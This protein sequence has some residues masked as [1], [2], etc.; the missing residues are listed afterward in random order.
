MR[1]SRRWLF[2][3]SGILAA[4]LLAALWL[5]GTESGTRWLVARAE[6]FLPEA[7]TLTGVS[8]T[9]LR[10][11]ELD[12]VK[13]LD[14]DI[15]VA[16]ESVSISVRPL[17]LISRNVIIDAFD[18]AA[19][20]VTLAGGGDDSDDPAGGLPEI[21]LPVDLRIFA[22]S[23]R[24]ID[25][26]S[27][28]FTREIDAVSFAGRLSG[29]ALEIRYF[30][31]ASSWLDIDI[32][33]DAQLSGRYPASLAA[34]WAWKTLDDAFSG[35]LS[36]DGDLRGFD[37]DHRLQAPVAVDS[38]GS[39][40][41]IDGVPR[42]DI[43][44]RWGAI[45]WPIPGGA[46][47]ARDGRLVTEGNLSEINV[48]LD[49]LAEWPGYPEQQLTLSGRADPESFAVESL[50]LRGPMGTAEISG[51]ASWSPTLAVALDYAVSSVD[52]SQLAPEIVS[53]LN[54]RGS[55]TAEQLGDRITA[56]ASITELDGTLNGLTVDGTANASSDGDQ[57]RIIDTQLRVGSN[58]VRLDGS[59]SET[60]LVRAA[61]DAPQLADILPELS[62]SVA[63]EI[64]V[65]GARDAPDV[66]FELSGN[67]LGWQ[68]T[69]N[70]QTLVA[71]GSLSRQAPSLVS[72]DAE[73][74]RFGDQALDAIGVEL[75]GTESRHSLTVSGA[76]YDSELAIELAGSLEGE[77]WTG[78]LDALSVVSPLIARW[79]TRES[80]DVSVSP[81]GFIVDETCLYQAETA[82][83]LC[84]FATADSSD[85][86]DARLQLEALSL[87][88]VQLP[89][90][91]E[92]DTSGQLHATIDGR[93]DGQALNA[94]TQLELRDGTVTVLYDEEPVVI[95]VS[96]L[97][98]EATVRANT[99]ASSLQLALG[100]AARATA[101]LGIDDLFDP[102][103]AITGRTSVAVP[104]VSTIAA[105]IPG[106]AEPE[107]AVDGT[108]SLSGR[109][110]APVFA[111]DVRLRDGRF[112]I[113]AAG[114]TVSDVSL[115]VTQLAP[116]QL[117]VLGSARS[118]EGQVAVTGRTLISSDTGLRSE[119]SIEGENVELARRPDFSVTASPTIDIVFD[120]RST[121]INGEL[122]IPSA[123]IRLRDIPA[124][125]ASPSPDTIVHE[126]DDTETP[127]ARVIDIDVSTS[128]GDDVNFSGFGL[129]TRLDG[130]L[131]LRGGNT[132]AY[133]GQGRVTLIG[134]EYKSYGQELEI[135]EGEL[136]FSGPLDNPRL[137]V[138]AVRRIDDI[139]AGI[140]L[141][142][143]PLQ[144]Q[145][146]LYSEPG[147]TDAEILS[148]L[149]T[150]R[151]L[152][153]ASDGDDGELLNQAAFSLGLSGAGAVVSRVRNSLGLE[154]L[155]FEGRGSSSRLV[156]GKRIGNRL[157]VEYGYGVV[158]QLG[159]LLLRYQLSD[160]LILESRTG[161]VSNLDLLY[162]V[163]KQ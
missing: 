118:G 73:A 135:E 49:T 153:G 39:V 72:L 19:L 15:N 48:A 55:V 151:P 84:L 154:T 70:V 121:T 41:I 46:A 96:E 89:L 33:G 60:L 3:T 83:A 129:T 128:L 45:E 61:F 2:A 94:E 21:E 158:D 80:S 99:L 50:R 28:A 116:G 92:L 5:L 98:A 115:R 122:A 149:L 87:D 138:R 163:K 120:E 117:R 86:V 159:T 88:S 30:T 114:T 110:A 53:A 24:R 97:V 69:A 78:R 82:A 37:V 43:E 148:Y 113:P 23:I 4:P 93:W 47:R 123:A 127:K 17:P 155:A 160:R 109:L 147:L 132:Q 108:L 131:R 20:S 9:V 142:G 36:L 32:S 57:I 124:G 145:S 10:G 130:D 105:L 74:V 102:D 12:A 126:A 150:G 140:R 54:A 104:D 107:G 156:A 67:E 134:G 101:T 146:T 58:R 143:T 18:V 52:V 141:S 14:S 79:E 81:N 106:I 68:E 85:V 6:S 112:A 25:V 137:N 162:S 100:D 125:A 34:N 31:L 29:D 13:W 77:R 42:F 76:G 91:P 1:I 75:A 139:V 90:P 44:N 27:P 8:G 65:Q 7:L 133:T 136:I 111:G 66:V 16:A 144:L 62:G 95:K 64:T 22:S 161:T 35:A 26:A 11:V 56:S 119:F 63:G 59:I 71:T 38:T 152:S 51:Q 157:L 40:A 103:A